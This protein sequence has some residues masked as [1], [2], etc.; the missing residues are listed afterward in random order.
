MT[1]LEAV[2]DYLRNQLQFELTFI[3][4]YQRFA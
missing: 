1:S 2:A 3:D 4:D